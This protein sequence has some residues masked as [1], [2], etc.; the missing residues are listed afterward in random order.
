MHVPNREN[1][2]QIGSILLISGRGSFP[3]TY[4]WWAGQLAGG[5]GGGRGEGALKGGGGKGGME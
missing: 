3:A 5:V 1:S 4:L 2:A